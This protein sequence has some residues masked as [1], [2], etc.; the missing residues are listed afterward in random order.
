VSRTADDVMTVLE[1]LIDRGRRHVPTRAEIVKALGRTP[2]RGDQALLAAGLFGAGALV[3]AGLAI[4]LAS[5]PD[6]GADALP[7]AGADVGG[8]DDRARGEA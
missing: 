8:G 5:R 1:E 3:G 4:L 6:R 7:A 2:R